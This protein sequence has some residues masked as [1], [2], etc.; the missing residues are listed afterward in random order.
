MLHD[1]NKN[2]SVSTCRA[3]FNARYKVWLYFN[4]N[5]VVLVQGFISKLFY[6][7]ELSLRNSD[8]AVTL[9]RNEGVAHTTPRCD[10]D[11]GSLP[12]KS[13]CH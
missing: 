11:Q 5:C 13:P 1:I 3:L 9:K 10:L 12:V 4:S 6:K 7:A 8:K 2:F